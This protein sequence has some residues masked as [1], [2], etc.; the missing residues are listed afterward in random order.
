MKVGSLRSCAELH[1]FLVTEYIVIVGKSVDVTSCY[2]NK[3][4]LGRH[5]SPNLLAGW[6]R[7]V[8]VCRRRR[9]RRCRRRSLSLLRS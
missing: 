1:V 8:V 5:G 7:V 3:R 2:G 4:I 6:L 9:R